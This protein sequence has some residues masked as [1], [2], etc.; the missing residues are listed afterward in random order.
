MSSFLEM[1]FI[2][3]I[4]LPSYFFTGGIQINTSATFFITEDGDFLVTSDGKY[5]KIR[6]R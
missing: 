5:Y 3:D 6:N 4:F 1:N 2:K